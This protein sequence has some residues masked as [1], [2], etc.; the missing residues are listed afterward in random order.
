VGALVMSFVALIAL[1]NGLLGFVGGF[2]GVPELTLQKILGLLF[3]PFALLMGIPLAEATSVG[4][5]LGVKTALNEF[6]AYQDLATLRAAGEISERS[7]IITSYALCGFANFGSLAILIG[8]I[9]GMAP[10]RRSD[11]A[12][13][14][15]RSILAGTL[16]TL[17]TGCVAG[18]LL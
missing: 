16:A 10:S 8:G 13:L 2:V 9:G 18:I 3:A 12:E 17:M 15:L 1:L 5:L 4:S 6:I 7:A 11:I 14:G